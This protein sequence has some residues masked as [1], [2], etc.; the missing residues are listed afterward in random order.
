MLSST[1]LNFSNTLVSLLSDTSMTTS[2]RDCITEFEVSL[3]YIPHLF[4]LSPIFQRKCKELSIFTAY[5]FSKPPTP[6]SQVV[7]VY[8]NRSGTEEE[9][10]AIHQLMD[11]AASYFA[12]MQRDK[13]VKKI[14]KR[15]TEDE[16]KQKGFEMR[17]A[18]MKTLKQSKAKFDVL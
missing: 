1:L 15:A 13:G 10:N 8:L 5:L 7:D 14:K 17:D 3:L 11:D 9:Y 12:D 2:V 18:A 16:D 6:P 4:L